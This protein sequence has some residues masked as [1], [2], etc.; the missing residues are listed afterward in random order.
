L[1]FLQQCSETLI[2]Q[3]L[4]TL[5]AIDAVG[6]SAKVLSSILKFKLLKLWLANKDGVEALQSQVLNN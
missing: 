1:T 5:N 6:K 2:S 4:A 3:L